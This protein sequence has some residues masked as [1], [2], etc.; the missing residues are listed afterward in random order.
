LLF[1]RAYCLFPDV[2][3]LQLEHF[4]GGCNHPLFKV[5]VIFVLA[6]ANVV[7]A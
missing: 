6:S 2:V 1:E 4:L 3:V 7:G 5:S